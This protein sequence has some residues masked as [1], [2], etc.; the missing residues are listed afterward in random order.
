MIDNSLKFVALYQVLARRVVTVM[1]VA[2][3]E[4]VLA[5]E[6]TWPAIAKKAPEVLKPPGYCACTATKPITH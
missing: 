1:A 5:P 2:N 3:C 6:C 4:D